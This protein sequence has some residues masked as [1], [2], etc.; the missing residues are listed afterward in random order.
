MN[1]FNHMNGFVRPVLLGHDSPLFQVLQSPPQQPMMPVRMKPGHMKPGQLK[2][3][4]LRQQQV[5]Q[6]QANKQANNV[7]ETTCL[8]NFICP[9][10]AKNSNKSYCNACCMDLSLVQLDEHLRTS[11]HFNNRKRLNNQ[12]LAVNLFQISKHYT[13][14]LTDYLNKSFANYNAFT[15]LKLLGLYL[16]VTAYRL[17]LS[18]ALFYAH[19]SIPPPDYHEFEDFL[20]KNLS[21][22]FNL[23]LHG[24]IPNDVAIKQ[25]DINVN[26]ELQGEREESHRDILKITKRLVQEKYSHRFEVLN[27]PNL[28]R[29]ERAYFMT[30]NGNLINLINID[31]LKYSRLIGQYVQ[32]DKRV[33]VLMYNLRVWANHCE[34]DQPLKATYRPQLIQIMVIYF[35]QHCNL[36]VLPNFH[37]ELKK[38]ADFVYGENENR[39]HP[40]EPITNE[41]IEQVRSSWQTKNTQTV[42]EL[43]IDFFKFYLFLFDHEKT[44]V[45][46]VHRCKEKTS[47]AFSV[48]NLIDG[49]VFS[50]IFNWRLHYDRLNKLL[51]DM[52]KHSC[53]FPYP[54]AI[55]NDNMDM[56][57]KFIFS[58]R[59]FKRNIDFKLTRK[60]GGL[61]LLHF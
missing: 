53:F 52:Y 26:I 54:N 44:Y 3:G 58:P 18:L 20:N 30:K 41:E 16:Q 28:D 4:Q 33:P 9:S 23:T 37:A 12:L 38:S 42:G 32:F 13:L 34:L 10:N 61:L 39:H 11:K 57:F 1:Q 24:S 40:V 45:N 56:Y 17:S 55:N 22:K 51:F 31:N 5:A 47:K 43:W 8:E 60:K 2:P 36:P 48:C 7:N 19:V 15:S 21:V 6:Q 25:S 29:H 50:V 14:S 49:T 46:I 27:V 35:L 59:N